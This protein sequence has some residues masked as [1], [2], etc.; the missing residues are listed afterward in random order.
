MPNFSKIEIFPCSANYYCGILP[1]LMGLGFCGI[2][3]QNQLRAIILRSCTGG[4]NSSC[5]CVFD[6]AGF[7]SG[8]VLG[9]GISKDFSVLTSSE[10]GSLR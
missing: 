1:P 2:G 8:T 10:V 6:C 4:A 7:M 9:M 3:K 5:A